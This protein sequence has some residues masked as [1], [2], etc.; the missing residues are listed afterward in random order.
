MATS[1]YCQT[2]LRACKYY[3]SIPSFLN[4]LLSSPLFPPL[5]F[6]LPPSPAALSALISDIECYW[7]SVAELEAWLGAGEARM[8]ECGPIGANLPRLVEQS[9]IL[10]V[11]TAVDRLPMVTPSH[12]QPSQCYNVTPSHSHS[13]TYHTSSLH[14]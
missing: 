11:G 6:L 12:H 9:P 4:P 8:E 1:S 14:M 3:P 7:S 2:P 5:S 10:E 13:I